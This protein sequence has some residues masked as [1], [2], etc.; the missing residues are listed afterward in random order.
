MSFAEF[1]AMAKNATIGTEVQI[2][3]PGGESYTFAVPKSRQ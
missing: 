2:L 1:I 3:R